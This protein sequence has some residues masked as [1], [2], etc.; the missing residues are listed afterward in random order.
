VSALA[1]HRAP[2]ARLGR[3]LVPGLLTFTV[4]LGADTPGGA[5]GL[6]VIVFTAFAVSV[7]WPLAAVLALE[8][9]GALVPCRLRAWW[10]RG[11]PRAHIP[12]W[13]RRVVYAADRHACAWCRSSASL[14]LDHIRPWSLG[15]RTSFFNIMTLCA[16][17][18]VAKSNYWA[19]RDGRVTYR[20]FEGHD[21]PRVAA[22][23][24]AYELRHRY[25]II[26]FIR[27]ALAL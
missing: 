8:A 11:A 19:D 21:A 26:R 9:P 27:A 20:P 15:G 1:R 25:S 18:N 2:A 5:D 13:L 3:W 4:W 22:A 16:A 14:Q 6:G 23:I 17:C 10:R 12:L 24:L 7:F